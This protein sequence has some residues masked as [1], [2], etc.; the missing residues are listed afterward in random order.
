MGLAGNLYIN[1]KATD[2]LGRVAAKATER[3][4][5]RK[6]RCIHKS[7]AYGQNIHAPKRI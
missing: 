7:R 3:R 2:M 5:T 4:E 6:P 1:R